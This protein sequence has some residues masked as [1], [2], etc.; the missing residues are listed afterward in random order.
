MIRAGQLAAT[1]SPALIAEMTA[2][3][4]ATK[5]NDWAKLVSKNV[6]LSQAKRTSSTATAE[7]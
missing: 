1:P 7:L 4:S 3:P 5:T 2:P 6:D